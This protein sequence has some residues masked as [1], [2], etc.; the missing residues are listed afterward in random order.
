MRPQ[1]SPPPLG[2]Q[3]PHPPP[4]LPAERGGP[5]REAGQEAGAAGVNGPTALELL[6]RPAALLSSSHLA[7]L[8]LSRRAI[9][10]VLRA[11]PVVI[12]PGYRRTLVKVEDFVALAEKGTECVYCGRPADTYD[13]VLPISRG[14][15]S[16]VANVV[17]ACRRCNSAKGARTPEEWRRQK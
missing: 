1:A 3:P 12:F 11:L 6:E 5:L 15:T 17:P 13:H 8:G 14:G 7:E 16:E 9:D 2:L 4:L 10:A